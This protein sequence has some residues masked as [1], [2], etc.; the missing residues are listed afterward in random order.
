MHFF[1]VVDQDPAFQVNP[2]SDP[3][4]IRSFDDQ[5]KIEEINIAEI[6]FLIKN[7][8][9]LIPRVKERP[10]Y[11]RSSH[12]ALIKIKFINFSIFVG[13]FCP[14][15]RIRNSDTDPGDTIDSGSSPDM[16]LDPQHCFL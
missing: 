6:S 10:S 8:S 5:A 15:I 16:D 4:R 12:P 13:Y 11:R 14:W 2:D 1:R 9:F 7:C 3:I